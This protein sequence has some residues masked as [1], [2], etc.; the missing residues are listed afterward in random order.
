MKFLLSKKVEVFPSGFRGEGYGK[1]RLTL[2]ENFT[3]LKVLSESAENNSYLMKDPYDETFAIICIHGYRFRVPVIDLE[4]GDSELADC[5]YAAIALKVTDG[6]STVNLLGNILCKITPTLSIEEKGVLDDETANSEFHGLVF[7]GQDEASNFENVPFFSLKYKDDQGNILW[8]SLKLNADEIRNEKN[9]P[10]SINEKFNTVDLTADKLNVTDAEITNLTNVAKVETENLKV[11]GSA[12]FDNVIVN[13][14]NGLTL[15]G[16]NEQ[17][18]IANKSNSSTKI[19]VAAGKRLAINT[20]LEVNTGK[21]TLEG[22]SSGSTLVLSQGYLYLPSNPTI[23]SQVMFYNGGVAGWK[24]ATSDSYSS[25]VSTN[26]IVM[27]D[28][29]GNFKAGTITANLSGLATKASFPEGFGGQDKKPIANSSVFTETSIITGWGHSS[30]Y[31]KFASNANK[32]DLGVNGYLYQNNGLSQVVDKDS[33]QSL[34]HKYITSDDGKKG[35]LELKPIEYGGFSISNTSNGGGTLK[36]YDSGTAALL[37]VIQTFTANKTFGRTAFFGGETYKIDNSGNAV[38]SKLAL[39]GG[40]ATNDDGASLSVDGGISIASISYF[41]GDVRITNGRKL[42][43]SHATSSDTYGWL[44]NKDGIQIG[45]G[46]DDNNILAQF[47]TAASASTGLGTGTLKITGGI[48]T[49]AGCYFNGATTFGGEVTS[50]SG[51]NVSSDI[52]LKENVKSFNPSKSILDLDV[53]EFDYKESK[54]HSIG[55]IAQD[56]KEIC[57]EIVHEDNDGYLSIEESKIV[58][59]LLDEVKKLR[60]EL[61]ELK[62]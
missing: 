43:W 58:Y 6:E 17:I 37:D 11:N 7:Y 14:A 50:T 15:A 22:N 21:V 18:N 33:D 57:P 35:Y 31:I 48:F 54:K 39:K 32:L 49:S 29:S 13:N 60:K 8:S 40:H 61:D 9:S 47:S 38:L 23:D 55:C 12:S 25:D 27:R 16:D 2:E 36:V 28:A 30:A 42:I 5:S 4:S 24:T 56:L 44:K 10:E 26:T 41:N 20:N 51:F 62:G 45:Y 52:R 59:L 3:N 34:K 46:N 1:S 19:T 53:K